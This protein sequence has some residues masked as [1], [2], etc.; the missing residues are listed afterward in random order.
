MK[1]ILLSVS[2]VL[3]FILISSAIAFNPLTVPAR[4]QQS[5]KSAPGERGLKLDNADKE[6]G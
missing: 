3:I 1:E 4:A 6:R 2:S 5:Y